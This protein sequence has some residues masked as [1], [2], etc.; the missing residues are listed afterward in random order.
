MSDLEKIKKER[1]ENELKVRYQV[2]CMLNNLG[3]AA[4]D[5]SLG[6]NDNNE[7]IEKIERLVNELMYSMPK[8]K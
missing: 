8:L 7:K 5:W 2:S 6:E 1:K 3:L 4:H